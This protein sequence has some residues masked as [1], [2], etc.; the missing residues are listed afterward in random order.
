MWRLQDSGAIFVC[1]VSVKLRL[2]FTAGPYW[3]VVWARC[4]VWIFIDL[5]NLRPQNACSLSFLRPAL[6]ICV[7]NADFCVNANPE[8]QKWPVHRTCKYFSLFLTLIIYIIKP[9]ARWIAVHLCT[10]EPF[11]HLL[12]YWLVLF[13][14]KSLPEPIV[15][16]GQLEQDQTKGNFN[17][18]TAMY[19]Q[20]NKM[21][22]AKMSAIF[23]WPQWVNKYLVLYIIEIRQWL[24]DFWETYSSRPWVMSIS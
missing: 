19:F 2:L 14:A 17:K 6:K 8:A 9:Q 18:I 3:Q 24:N 21:S 4:A 10:S 13:C 23:F 5:W 20:E 16:C 15:T 11:P 1:V 22:S 7:K 12:R